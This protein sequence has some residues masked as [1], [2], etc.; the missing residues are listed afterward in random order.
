[1]GAVLTGDQWPLIT[2]LDMVDGPHQADQLQAMALVRGSILRARRNASPTGVRAIYSANSRGNR[3]R[4]HRLAVF[5]PDPH[6]AFRAEALR[7]AVTAHQLNVESH[8]RAE[9]V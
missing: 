6:T 1:V 2:I 9:R 5:V 3:H 7:Q 8:Y 4:E